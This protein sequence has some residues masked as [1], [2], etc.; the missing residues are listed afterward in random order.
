VQSWPLTAVENYV[1]LDW[2]Q[3]FANFHA[4]HIGDSFV[5]SIRTNL[6]ELAVEHLCSHGGACFLPGSM[7]PG[8]AK[9]GVYA[10]R[11]APNFSRALAA[12]YLSN[13]QQRE[14]IEKIL[15]YLKDTRL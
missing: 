10:V 7:R 2:G 5:P 12:S 6:P 3:R 9:R 14:L 13:S 1:Y 4:R 11:N 8:L 15:G